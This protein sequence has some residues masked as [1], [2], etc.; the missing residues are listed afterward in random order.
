MTSDVILSP[1]E[2]P[3]AHLTSGRRLAHST[4]WNL[5][6]TAAPMVVAV[7]CIRVL[8]KDLGTDRFGVLSL[9][10]ALIGY[11]SLFDLGLGR[12]LTQLVANK[13]G[14][15]KDHEIPD[16]VWTS[17]FM[18]LLLGLGAAL[19]VG[20]LSPW[21][22]HRVFR[23]P[24]AL[25]PETVKSLY[26]LGA[27]LPSVLGTAGLVGFLTAYQRF[28]VITALR[29]PLGIVSYAGPLIVVPFSNS[30]FPVVAVIVAGRFLGFAIHLLF[31]LRVV[32]GLASNIRWQSAVVAPLLRF[33]GWM[34]VSN[35]ISPLMVTLDRFVIGAMLPVAAVAYYATVSDVITKLWIIPGAL[36]AVVFPAFSTSFAQN[37]HR[38][39]FLYLR[40]LK[41][42][43]LAL[44]PVG[45]LIMLFAQNGLKLWLGQDF[46][47]HS[48]R[49]LQWL[50]VGVLI[51]SLAGVP[52]SLLQGIG[53]PNLTA[54]LHLL[55][56]PAYLFV[57]WRC[58]AL[59]GIEGAAIAWTARVTVDAV[60]LFIL[61]KRFLP[62]GARGELRTGV[63]AFTALLVLVLGAVPQGFLSK[64]VFLSVATLGFLLIAWFRLLAPEERSFTRLFRTE[65]NTGAA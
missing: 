15:G 41:Y 39:A 29:I 1:N 61:A 33:G 45:L 60:A 46:A 8:I 4:V 53:R 52:F 65:S 54:T 25:Q 64:T 51:N 19:A 49:V 11:A 48:F 27:S 13:L 24:A 22:A 9:V 56:L 47:Q 21:L 26:L 18:M 42:L 6:G 57:L 16:F 62:D 31:A 43:L 7:I 28:D 58:I 55:E 23:I 12:A 30:L 20:L 40:S 38:T 14:A 59:W 35:V 5:V 17:L 2:A 34:T 32:P 50:V 37:P 44:F 3:N 63:L 36:V 10:W